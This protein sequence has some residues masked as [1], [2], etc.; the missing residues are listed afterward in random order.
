MLSAKPTRA[1]VSSELIEMGR[2]QFLFAVQETPMFALELMASLE[3][4]LR[5]LE[6]EAP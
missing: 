4:R 5:G 3:A 6:G 1:V 2:E